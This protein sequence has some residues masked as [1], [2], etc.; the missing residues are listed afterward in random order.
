[1]Y[2]CILLYIFCPVNEG[3]NQINERFDDLLE[4]MHVLFLIFSLM[5]AIDVDLGFMCV[6][7]RGRKISISKN[8]H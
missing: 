2:Y 8:E 3:V 6:T 1:M 5:L 4:A 7:N